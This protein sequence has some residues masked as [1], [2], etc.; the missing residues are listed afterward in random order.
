MSEQM[1]LITKKKFSRRNSFHWQ[2]TYVFTHI[3][4]IYPDIF[5]K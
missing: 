1:R 5:S 2:Y 3:V 4:F